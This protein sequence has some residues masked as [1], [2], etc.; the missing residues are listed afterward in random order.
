MKVDVD[1]I[2]GKLANF[3]RS[4]IKKKKKKKEIKNFHIFNPLFVQSWQ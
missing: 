2:K 1:M 4:F 3:T